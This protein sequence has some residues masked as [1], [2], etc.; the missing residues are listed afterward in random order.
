MIPMYKYKKK[1]LYICVDNKFHMQTKTT[2]YDI[3]I[4]NRTER[5]SPFKCPQNPTISPLGNASIQLRHKMSP[6][7]INERGTASNLQAIYVIASFHSK[8]QCLPPPPKSS[9][10]THEILK[11]TPYIHITLISSNLPQYMYI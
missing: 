2:D 11:K 10:K 6:R 5:L 7:R 8:N 1:Y 3:N 9:I 4:H